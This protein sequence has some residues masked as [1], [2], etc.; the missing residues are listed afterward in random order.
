MAVVRGV[1][2]QVITIATKILWALD[3]IIASSY[4]YYHYNHIISIEDMLSA[5]LDVFALNVLY[6]DAKTHLKITKIP[7]ETFFWYKTDI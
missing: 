3:Q 5:S 7:Y 4:M 1:W 2:T 6:T